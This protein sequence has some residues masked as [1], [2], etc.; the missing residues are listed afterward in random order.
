MVSTIAAIHA[1]QREERERAEEQEEAVHPRV[2]AVVDRDPA[3][4]GERGGDERGALV[5][6]PGDERRDHGHA[7]DREDHGHEPKCSQAGGDRAREVGQEPVERRAAPLGEDCGEDIAD[8]LLRHE[9]DESLVLVWRPHRHLEDEEGGERRRDDADS[10][11]VR[12]LARANQRA[13]EPGL[14]RRPLGAH[15]GGGR[16]PW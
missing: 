16:P 8:R 9:E 4:G 14:A 6:E 12:V 15:A 5:R 11:P 2:D 1:V 3:G 13:R 10:E 7:R